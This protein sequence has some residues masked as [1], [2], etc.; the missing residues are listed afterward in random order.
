MMTKKMKFKLNKL[1]VLVAMLSTSLAFGQRV[2]EKQITLI[3]GNKTIIDQLKDPNINGGISLVVNQP[4]DFVVHIDK[5]SK[6]ISIDSSSQA[7]GNRIITIEYVT[8]GKLNYRTYVL[9]FVKSIVQAKDDVVKNTNSDIIVDILANDIVSSDVEIKINQIPAGLSATVENGKIKINSTSDKTEYVHYSIKDA[10]GTTSSA[11]ITVEVPKEAPTENVKY[12]IYLNYLST[13]TVVLPAGFT[14]IVSPLHGTLSSLD[15]EHY[16]Y[17]PQEYYIGLDAFT[18]EDGNKTKIEYKVTVLDSDKDPG[19]VKN[20]V[21]FTAKNTAVTFDVFSNDLVRKFAVSSASPEL[22]KGVQEGI[23]TYTPPTN[24]QGIKTFFY[25]VANGSTIESGKVQVNV[26]NFNPQADISYAFTAFN[27]QDY[28]IEYNVPI[29]G[30]EFKILNQPKQGFAKVYKNTTG[31]LNCGVAMGKV[32]ITYT[33]DPGYV[34]LDEFDVNYCING[35]DCRTYKLKFDVVSP[36]AGCVCIDNCV[37]EGDLNGDGRVTP[38]DLMVLGRHLGAE[39]PARS[40]SA[41]GV[42]SAQSSEDWGTTSIYGQDIKHADANGD[43]RLTAEDAQSILDNLGKVNSLVKTE[44]LGY[45]DYPFQLIA[46]PEVAQKDEEQSIYMI[47]GTADRPA[48][49]IYGISLGLNMGELKDSAKVKTTFYNDSWLTEHAPNLQIA[50]QVSNGDFRLAVTKSSDKSSSGH[51]VVGHMCCVIVG[52]ADGVRSE[53]DRNIITSSVHATSIVLEDGDGQKFDV[54]GASVKLRRIKEVAPVVNEDAQFAIYPNPAT[55]GKITILGNKEIHTYELYN[56]NG[57]I[58]QRK[59]LDKDITS[60][61]IK[62][63]DISTGIYL[64]KIYS[65]D[66][67][68]VKKV[69]IQH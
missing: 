55:D 45:K 13:K 62:T 66:G 21:V 3:S 60:I 59:S 57:S 41:N 63:Q 10:L 19:I 43:G 1:F 39:G 49:G 23:F 32:I 53:S 4:L 52:D 50:K 8:N 44:N 33:A 7:K 5:I 42:W 68:V 47:L 24:F 26:G 11:V 46:V 25:K 34:G 56:M 48:N 29:E 64:L 14:P 40:A 58:L 31:N 22:V 67:V 65:K 36:Q 15:A 27:G 51:G 2:S 16:I 30:Y 38:S 6:E 54:E 69:A 9:N 35:K 12:D 20:D 18:F 28:I 17:T 61:S 37:W